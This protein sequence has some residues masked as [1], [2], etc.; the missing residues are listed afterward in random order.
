MADVRAAPTPG[1]AAPAPQAGVDPFA[2]LARAEERA[3][4]LADAARRVSGSLDLVQTRH[5]QKA[6]AY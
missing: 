1:S 4:F 3:A 2:A 6:D 5:G